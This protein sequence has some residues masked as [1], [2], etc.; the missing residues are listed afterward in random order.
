MIEKFFNLGFISVKSL[1]TV[2]KSLLMLSMNISANTLFQ[3]TFIMVPV[4]MK[5]CIRPGFKKHGNIEILG[6]MDCKGW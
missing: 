3:Y 1:L 6:K 4:L 2:C 5:E